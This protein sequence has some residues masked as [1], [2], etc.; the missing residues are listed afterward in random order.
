MPMNSAA[1]HAESSA[2]AHVSTI[3][4]TFVELGAVILF[5]SLLA[6]IAM[7][8][9]LTP[10]P[11]YLIAGL[12]LGQGGLLHLSLSENFISLGS[13][14]GVI[15][16]LFM[17]G[18]EYTGE[19]LSAGLR[20]GLRGGV[21]DFTL[22]LTP[23]FLAGL[24]L[25][26]SP[27]A[28]LLLGGVTYISSSSIIAKVLGDLD[29]LGNR[30]T[31]SVLSVL[32]LEDLAMAV[33]LPLVAVLLLGQGF[34]DGLLAITV[35]LVTVSIVLILA[36]KQGKRISRVVAHQSD[37]VLLL[38]VFGLVL[39]VAGIAQRLQV[40]AAIGAFL[41]GLALSGSVAEQARGLLGPLRD[42]F[43]TIFFFFVGL[44][45]DP[46]SLPPV[47]LVALGLAVVTAA[48]KIA[49]GW[50]AAS[51]EG[52]GPRGRLRAGLALV[53]RGEFSVVI[54]NLGAATE[55]RLAPL[56]A[57]Y[58][59]ILAIGGPLLARFSEPLFNLMQRPAAAPA[60]EPL[61]VG[62]SDG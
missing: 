16:L 55:P 48:T 7:R 59:L 3:A 6:R 36:V 62:V 17:L 53:A 47:L 39:L 58:V 5:L 57:A 20:R 8:G 41:V 18:L 23:G 60:S 27:L 56:A 28:A 61:A 12:C 50:Q 37:E 29:R 24:L 54:A 11:L 25:G 34:L 52:I 19:E 22:N 40:S 26:W 10:I 2:A 4:S 30:E 33:F 13:E 42:L 46:A 45:I 15:L 51:W 44:Q 38:T 32:V 31:P 1:P 21:L 43:A 35:A 49:T 9:G 14:I